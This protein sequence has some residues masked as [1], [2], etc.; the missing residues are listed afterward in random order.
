M[1]PRAS[2]LSAPGPG[3]RTL[4]MNSRPSTKPPG[5]GRAKLD[6]RLKIGAE[7][8]GGIG[9]GDAPAAIAAGLL[10]AGVAVTCR[11]PGVLYADAGELL[12]AVASKGV[13]H[14]PGFPLYLIFGGFWLDAAHALGAA[15]ASSLNAFSAVCAGIA[16]AGA[17]WGASILLASQWPEAKPLERR[18]LAACAGLLVGFGPT[19]FDFS[20]GIE[21]YAFHMALVSFAVAFAMAALGARKDPEAVRATVLSG[22]FAGG[23]LA[24]H[25]ATI[26]VILPGLAVLLWRREAGRRRARRVGLFMAAM[27]PGLLAYASLPLR[28]PRWAALNWGNPSNPFRFWVHI[29]ARVYQVNIESS[30]AVIAEHARR[31]LEAYRDEFSLPGLALALLGAVAFWKRG[32][33]AV[34][35]LL[36]IILGDIAFAV[37]YE[38]AEDQAAYYLPT[39]LATSVLAVLGMAAVLERLK[40][41]GGR[42]VAAA[43]ALAGTLAFTGHD[44]LLRAGR[45]RDGRAPETAA[46]VLASL[47]EGALAFT[48]EWNLYAPVMA[49]QD[50]DGKRPDALVLDVLLLR[51][52]WYLDAFARRHPERAA[53]VNA[54]LSAYR[55]RL[56]DWEEGRPYDGNVLTNLFEAFTRKLVTEAWRRGAQVVWFGNPMLKHLP[57]GAGLVPSGIGYRIVPQMTQ[58]PLEDAAVRFDAVLAPDL[59]VDETF[60]LKIRPLYALVR[61]RRAL[62]EE[63]FQRRDAARAAIVVARRIAPG[64]S[65]A[66][67]VL[68]DLLAGD[69]RV[70]EALRA[71]AEAIQK[72]GD[73]VQIGGKSRAV[74]ERREGR[75]R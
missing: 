34:G 42:R 64:S 18:L 49:A 50:V 57:P 38:I 48:P 14:P 33:L 67:E 19:L 12:T 3:T 29:S 74:L 43:A 16:A 39:F 61:I 47:P 10:V 28:A 65:A 53:E 9:R 37:R 36:T 69:G 13:A 26:A 4:A 6:R 32:R 25:H 40:T 20:L 5:R 58:T 68:G 15:P 30:P 55:T 8:H 51:R 44:V 23:A 27:V 1:P 22:L 72:G 66:A 11:A 56:A 21:V 46:N 75:S 71:Y 45:A 35:G 17:T 60:E 7:A 59:P 24:V 63:S 54:E 52:G 2:E 31:F 41:P 70:D 73:A 62:Y